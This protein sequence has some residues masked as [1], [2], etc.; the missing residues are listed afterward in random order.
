[1]KPL[2]VFMKPSRVSKMSFH[3]AEF[4]SLCRQCYRFTCAGYCDLYDSYDTLEELINAK[5]LREEVKKFWNDHI[6]FY[7]R[8]PIFRKMPVYG[9]PPHF[10]LKR[11]FKRKLFTIF[12]LY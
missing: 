1:M 7:I 9:Y 3:V 6:P 5:S 2:R 12:L 11:L 8:G 4:S 10:P